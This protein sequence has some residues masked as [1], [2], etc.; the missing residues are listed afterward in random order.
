MNL[1]TTYYTP[2]NSERLK[3]INLCLQKNVDNKYIKKIIL[4]NNEFFSLDFIN[5]PFK[6]INQIIISN[7]QNYK[8]KFNDAVKYIN[9]YCKDDICILANS[10]IYFNETLNKINRFTV[11]PDGGLL[12]DLMW[13][14][15]THITTNSTN[16]NDSWGVNSRGVSCTYN[17]K[18]VETFLNNNNL[19]LICRAHQLVSD[20]YKFSHNNKL[21][22]VFSAP[23]YCGNC[24]N[25]GAVMKISEDL[26]CSFII[27]KPTNEQTNS[28]TI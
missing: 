27:I 19:Q 17:L 23:N 24:G 7:N 15:P 10:D 12:C 3:E 13:S 22:T 14:D 6:K 9:E 25:D 5:D 2:S 8:L 1:I 26:V 16:P 21:I 4:L 18:A 11:I 28:S 20:G